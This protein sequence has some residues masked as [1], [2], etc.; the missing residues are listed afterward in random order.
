M[1]MAV[2]TGMPLYILVFETLLLH[3]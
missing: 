1:I 2:A 3:L